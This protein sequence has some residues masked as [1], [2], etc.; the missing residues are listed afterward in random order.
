M[1]S[2]DVAAVDEMKPD[3]GSII[4]IVRHRFPSAVDVHSRTP[5]QV[6]GFITA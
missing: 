4:L 1:G 6:H 2:G 3:M 5:M